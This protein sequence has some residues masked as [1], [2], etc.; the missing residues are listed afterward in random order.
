MIIISA[1]IVESYSEPTVHILN[2]N[3]ISKDGKQ[4]IKDLFGSA[5]PK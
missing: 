4:T 3:V 2:H 1:S 5:N